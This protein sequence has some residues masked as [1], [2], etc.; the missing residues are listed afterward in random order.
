MLQERSL[1]SSLKH[2]QHQYSLQLR[3]LSHSV[4]ELEA[5]LDGVREGLAA[6]KQQH[7][8]LLNTKMRL[9]KEITTYRRLLEHEEGRCG[10]FVALIKGTVRLQMSLWGSWSFSCTHSP[11]NY[12]NT[13]QS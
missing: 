12:S 6:Q 13:S 8:E 9:E 10:A 4:C 1:Q 11:V 3:D 2:T 7:N 5:E